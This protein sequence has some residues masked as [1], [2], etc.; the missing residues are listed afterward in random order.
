MAESLIQIKRSQGNSAPA[1]LRPGELAYSADET[2]GLKQGVLYIGGLG[3]DESGHSTEKHIIGG[4]K[5]TTLLDG[6]AGVVTANKAIIAGEQGE[7][8][9]LKA[10]TIQGVTDV[11]AGK[12]VLTLGTAG[13]KVIIEEPFVKGAGIGG[14][15]IALDAFVKKLVSEGVK[16]KAGAG[17][18]E[19]VAGPDGTMTIGLEKTGVTAKQYG[20]ATKIPVVTVNEYGQITAAEEQNISTTLNLGDGAG[21]SG[22]VDLVNGKLDIAGS[23]GVTVELAGGKFTLGADETFVK[24]SGAQTVGGVKTFSDMPIVS[25]AQ[26]DIKTGDVNEVTKLGTLKAQTVY[27]DSSEAGTTVALGGIPKGTKYKDADVIKIL[28]E[29]LHPYVAPSAVNV[30]LNENGGTFEMGVV[31]TISSGTVRWANGSTKVNKVEI[32]SGG[33]V[34]GT[35]AVEGVKTSQAVTLSESIQVKTNTSFT[36]RVTE[37]SASKQVSGGNVS[38]NFVYPFYHGV[39]DNGVA[40][41]EAAIKKLTKDISAKG[42]KSYA[43]DTAGVEKQVVIAYPASYGNLRSVLDPNKFENIDKFNGAK[44]TVSITGLDDTPQQYTVYAPKTNVSNMKFTFSF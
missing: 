17:I 28:H 32:L 40:V 26:G 20:S 23:N 9:T 44:S 3:V 34:K 1:F 19:I 31:K 42:S 18:A 36:A 29:L 12:S 21:A 14:E 24:T 22:S 8:D 15:D 38:F 10:K 5:Y 4:K 35:S 30:S 2:S 39:V 27:T 13:G 43:Y 37:D 11:S 6:K 33:T 41:D 25:A 7:V 16:L